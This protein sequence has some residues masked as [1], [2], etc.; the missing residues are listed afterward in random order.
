MAR[1]STNRP[2]D[3]RSAEP[4][5]AQPTDQLVPPTGR[6]KQIFFAYKITKKVDPKLPLAVFGSAAAAAVVM[7]LLAFF[8]FL[9]AN[10]ATANIPALIL[11]VL[12]ILV[13]AALT[14]MFMLNRRLQASQYRQIEGEI[15]AA[16]AVLEQSLKR[17][18]WTL[19]PAVQFN[20]QQDLVHRLIGRGGILLV[21]EGEP[22]RTAQL[23]AAERKAV[24]RYLGPDVP[25]DAIMV[26]DDTDAGQIPLRRLNRVVTQRGLRGNKLTAQQA[27]DYARRLKAI[28]GNPV[29]RMMPKGPIP[30]GG[31]I[32][33]GNLK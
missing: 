13:A 27:A 7:A 10:L 9:G 31:R 33:R 28:S 3:A 24:G 22:G 18:K 30:R 23:F 11:S 29:D 32:P 20:R 21:G 26:G 15:G 5:E 12:L 17:G 6:V 19:T 4:A 16:A 1:N 14:A 25:V 2:A 8:G